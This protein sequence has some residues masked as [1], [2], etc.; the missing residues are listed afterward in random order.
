MRVKSSKGG[1]AI[2]AVVTLVVCLSGGSWMKPPGSARLVSIEEMP[3][4]GETCL[5]AEASTDADAGFTANNLLAAFEAQTV[6]A[7]QS[8]DDHWAADVTRPALRTIRDTDSIYTAV[9]VDTRSNEVYL[10]DSNKWG[11]RVFNRL[12][13][14]SPNAVRSE[15]KRVIIGPKTQL[16][17]NSAIYIDPKNGDIYSVENDTGDS[18]VVFTH[19]A[20]GDVEPVRELHVT[21]RGFAVAVDEEKQEMYLSVNNPPQVAVY[22]KTASGEEKP[23]RVLRGEHTRL[24][25]AHGVA[26]DLKNKLL[27]VNG[28]GNFT[29]E[30]TVSGGR[31]EPASINIYAIDVKGDTAPV[32]V[33]QGPKTQ[34]NWPGAMALDPDTG[35]LYVANDGGQSLLVFRGPMDKGDVAPARVIKGNKTGL[36][37]P[38]G[39]T[40]DT[41]NKELWAVNL[42]NSSATVYPL[43]ANGNVA[44]LRTIRS[45]PSDKVSLRFGKTSTVAYDTKREQILVPN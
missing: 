36:S 32:R 11:I 6:Y 28:W 9:A 24:A 4:A 15:P 10:Q 27:F 42:G 31:S 23:L 7:A 8:R 12:E 26:L 45:A 20:D 3:Q 33:I 39:L 35:D 38:V 40:I 19:D 25:D 44:P 5:M 2:V 13:N 41:K 17:F 21:H 1:I 18:I 22:R 30:G 29:T 16:Q 14:T 34:L 37:Y 43:G